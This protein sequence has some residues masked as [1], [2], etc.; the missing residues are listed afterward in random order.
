VEDIKIKAGGILVVMVSKAKKRKVVPL[1]CP[2]LVISAPPF[3]LSFFVPSFRSSFLFYFPQPPLPF[4]TA[5]TA[6]LD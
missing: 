5:S 6:L 4:H 2:S 1:P 3:L